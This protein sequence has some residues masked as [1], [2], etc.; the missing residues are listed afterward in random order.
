MLVAVAGTDLYRY[1]GGVWVHM[2]A[3]GRRG[4]ACDASTL[5]WLTERGVSCGPW[6]GVRLC[7]ALSFVASF[8][9]VTERGLVVGGAGTLRAR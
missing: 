2:G 3:G 7:Y 1:E 6:E 8:V 5:Y 4:V 9:G